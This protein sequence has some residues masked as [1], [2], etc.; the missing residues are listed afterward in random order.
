MSGWTKFLLAWLGV[1]LIVGPLVA[2]YL[3]KLSE[4]DDFYMYRGRR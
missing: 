3:K 2:K 4:E 1:A